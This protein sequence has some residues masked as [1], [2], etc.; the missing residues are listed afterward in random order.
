MGKFKTAFIVLSLM[1]SISS[2]FA[3]TVDLKCTLQDQ[4]V[5][6]N[7]PNWYLETS[8]DSNDPTESFKE[9]T[10]RFC[11][12][13]FDDNSCKTI[14]RKEA[15]GGN[16]HMYPKWGAM[17]PYDIDF[18]SI[19][20]GFSRIGFILP[21]KWTKGLENCQKSYVSSFID[22]GKN[23]P[24]EAQEYYMPVFGTLRFLCSRQARCIPT[25]N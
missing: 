4:Y 10:L 3:Y 1:S 13:P 23:F 25:E 6:P 9:Y 11:T 5:Q 7:V 2:S 8:G 12:N 19:Y 17:K 22:I 24:V 15:A 18:D 14:N 20:P 16:W 21:N